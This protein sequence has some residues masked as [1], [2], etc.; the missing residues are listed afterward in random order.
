MFLLITKMHHKCVAETGMFSENSNRICGSML[1]C[2]CGCVYF[3]IHYII[4]ELSTTH[5]YVKLNVYVRV[6]D[7]SKKIMF[8]P[9]R[10]FTISNCSFLL[11]KCNLYVFISFHK[12]ECFRYNL[13]SIAR[14]SQYIENCK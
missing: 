13:L 7:L 4:V 11:T 10:R 9:L 2:V 6:C 8:Y 5:D 14:K 3:A 12:I 1:A